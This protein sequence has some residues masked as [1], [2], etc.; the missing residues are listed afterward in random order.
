MTEPAVESPSEPRRSSSLSDFVAGRVTAWQRDYIRRRPQALAILARLR[1]GVGKQVGAM[2]DLWQ[3]T[4]EGIP[5]PDAP[6]DA[7]PTRVEQAV[8]TALTL[9]AVHQQSRREEIGR[10]HV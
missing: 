8:Y 2:P 9:F 7:P 1:R 10:A 3:Y 4:L 6:D 5:G